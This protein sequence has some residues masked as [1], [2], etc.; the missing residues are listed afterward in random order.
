MFIAGSASAPVFRRQL[1]HGLPLVHGFFQL[2]AL[3]HCIAAAG[4]DSLDLLHLGTGQGVALHGDESS[5]P[6]HHG[7]DAEQHDDHPVHARGVG[8]I[9]GGQAL[10]AHKADR[11]AHNGSGQAGHQLVH[12]AEQGAHD[13]G[14][15]VAA[16]V[17]LVVGA[18]GNHRDG[19]IG[20]GVVRTVADAEEGDEQDGVQVEGQAVLAQNG[21]GEGI[22][23]APE[24][25]QHQHAHIAYQRHGD[26]LHQ[27][28][29]LAL[30]LAG[31]DGE[32]EEGHTAHIAQHHHGQVQAVVVAHH[33]AVQHTQHSGV[34]G[35]GKCQL[36]AR[37]GHHQPLHG[38]IVLDDLEVLAHLDLLGF[39]AAD[40]EILGLILFPDAN[41]S[42]QGEQNRDNDAH[43]RQRAEE[44]GRGVA[45]LIV[46]GK[47]RGKELHSAHAQQAAHGVEDGEQR[48]LLGV[49]GQYR[50]AGAGAAGLEGVADDPHGVQS[51]KG[52]VAQPHG[53]G[54]DERGKAIQCQYTGR[55]D[56]VA[57]DHERSELAE[58]AVGAVHESTDDGVGDSVKQTHSGDH[59]RGK[60]HAQGQHLAA[61]GSD[62]GKHQH[63]VHIRCAVV[64]RK[65]HQLVGFGAVH[66][67]RRC[68]LFAHCGLS[69]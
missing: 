38:V 13:A 34:V 46:L 23:A 68:F 3:G 55:H 11:N 21:Q 57:D 40:A 19:H 54:G 47:D 6:S 43:G 24:Q 63:I 17:G 64:Q 52:G 49:V 26:V 22:A 69:F 14:D 50:L 37:T 45:A 61:E 27:A 32:Q 5:R 10:Q 60:Q 42:Q 7:D 39:A 16:A 18:V 51:H 48:T 67:R 31:A 35:N 29:L 65:Q 62:V 53:T 66:T 1:L 15:V 30:L 36:A 44:P 25:Q 4:V 33:A 8:V 20:G 58:L 56:E 41:D 9:L 28:G 2:H 59:H 12:Q